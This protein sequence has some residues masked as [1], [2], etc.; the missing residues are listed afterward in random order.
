MC[1]S[2]FVR[3]EIQVSKVVQLA[4]ISVEHSDRSVS[5]IL[6]SRLL[7]C[8]FYTHKRRKKDTDVRNSETQRQMNQEGN[9]VFWEIL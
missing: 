5:R 9:G 4:P 8:C 7:A 2:D 1:L 6:T 3:K